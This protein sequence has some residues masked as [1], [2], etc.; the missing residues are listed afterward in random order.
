MTFSEL[1]KRIIRALQE[2]LPLS[3]TPYKEL[4]QKMDIDEDYLLSKIQS[5]IDSG[6]IRRFGATLKHRKIGYDANAMVVWEADPNL[7]K[8]IGETMAQFK[9]VSHCYERPTHPKWPYNMFTM[10]HGKTVKECEIVAKQI[11]E[12][13]N[14]SNYQILYSSKEFKKTS[15]RYFI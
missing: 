8:K 3:P 9:E 12:A 1:D 6:I 13:T 5:Y 7:T 4:A 10:V 2:D 11:S 14:L 15:M